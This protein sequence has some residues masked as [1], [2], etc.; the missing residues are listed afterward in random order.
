MSFLILKLKQKL[1]TCILKQHKTLLVYVYLTRCKT[2]FKVQSKN[3]HNHCKLI[4]QDAK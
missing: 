4:E 3:N 1:M 2:I